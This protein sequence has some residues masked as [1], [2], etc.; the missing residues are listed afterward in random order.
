[1]ATLDSAL[2][3][4][5]HAIQ[6]ALAGAG[7]QQKGKVFVGWP[8]AT[9]WE[10]IAGQDASG[11]LVSVWPMPGGKYDDPNP[12]NYQN[13]VAPSPGTTATLSASGLTLTIGG[14][15]K[16][17]DVVHAFFNTPS[18]DAFHAVVGTDTPATIAT[19]IAVAVNAFGFQG[20]SAN[21]AGD[22]VT[23]AGSYFTRAN[24]GSTGSTSLEVARVTRKVMVTVWTSSANDQTNAALNDRG[25]I[26]EVVLA[27][28]G[29]ATTQWLTDASGDQV[30]VT[31]DTDRWDDQASDSYAT[32][33]WD[34][35]Y[36]V[37]YSVMQT[38]QIAQLESVQNIIP[39]HQPATVFIG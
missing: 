7:L 34:I 3:A 23:I 2:G 24:V 17:G 16:V 29:T 4:V 28:V 31:L 20:I 18:G 10:E 22:V 8:T 32:F 11:A 38:M 6:V 19:S 39:A 27:S 26:G 15:P 37:T 35:F 14:T 5:R 25:E 21:A 12:L 30:F 33:R 9:E 36:D 13:T 1:M